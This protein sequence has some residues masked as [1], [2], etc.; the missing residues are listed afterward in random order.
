MTG[1]RRVVAAVLLACAAAAWAQYPARPVRLVSPTSPGGA[2]DIA[3]RTLAD[4]LA[5]A[6]G[7]PVVVENR[8]GSNGNIAAELVARSP[9]D[10]HTLLLGMDSLFVINPHVYG[11]MP[12]DDASLRGFIN[13]GAGTSAR[14]RRT[15]S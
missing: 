9:A 5:Q 3:A 12:I 7:Q 11:R 6:L 13:Q 4:K 14:N 2:P 15:S 8:I 1:F 10:G